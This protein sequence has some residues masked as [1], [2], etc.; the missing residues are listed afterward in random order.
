MSYYAGGGVFRT[1]DH[2]RTGSST[3]TAHAL[4]A[5]RAVEHRTSGSEPIAADLVAEVQTALE[6]MQTDD[7]CWWDKWHA[8]P[9]YASAHVL[10]ALRAGD[11]G[12]DPVVGR[13]AREWLLG[14]QRRDGSWGAFD[15]STAEETAYA[16]MALGCVPATAS[17]ERALAK[18]R[19]YIRGIVDRRPTYPSLY[20][21]KTLYCP[22]AIV[23][24]AVVGVSGLA[25]S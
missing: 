17:V 2:E 4:L 19:E 20:I 1:Y 5:L 22:H 25:P 12:L 21:G 10:F 23:E 24:S 13:L 8:S 9:F 18:G 16:V 15:L 7:G 14:A 6:G 11:R 3:T